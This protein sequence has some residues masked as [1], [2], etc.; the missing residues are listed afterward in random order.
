VAEAVAASLTAVAAAQAGIVP[1]LRV[2]IRVAEL[3]VT[4][5]FLSLLVRRSLSRLVLAVQDRRVQETVR[6]ELTQPSIRWRPQVAVAVPL[7]TWLGLMVVLEEALAFR[8]A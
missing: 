1:A 5:L 7:L 6:A 4:V 8:G 3:L 2:K